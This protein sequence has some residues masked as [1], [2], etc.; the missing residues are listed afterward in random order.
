MS[1]VTQD[2]TADDDLV[3]RRA[4]AI[5]VSGWG[6]RFHLFQPRNACF[7]V[8]LAL[9]VTGLVKMVQMFTPL[10]GYFAPAFAAAGAIACAAPSPGG[11]GSTTSTTSSASP[12]VGSPVLRVGRPGGT[13]RDLDR[14]QHRPGL[15][16]QQ[17]CLW[18]PVER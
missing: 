5:E 8:V 4:E 11:G 9:S 1:V 3:R 17:A 14:R 2:P 7:W 13:V 6:E 18:G 16:L 10:A 12:S 15:A